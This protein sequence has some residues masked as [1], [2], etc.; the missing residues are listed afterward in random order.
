MVWMLVHIKL[1]PKPLILCPFFCSQSTTVISS[2]MIHSSVSSH[3]LSRVFFIKITVFF[4][5]VY[6]FIFFASL[7]KASDFSLCPSSLLL[8][9]L[10]ILTII[11]SSSLLGWLLSPT[12]LS[13]S[14]VFSCS[15]MKNIFL[16]HFIWPDF[17]VLFLCVWWWWWFSCW[18]MSDSLW[19]HGL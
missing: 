7:L 9:S 8:S 1:A 14:T 18:V 15:K 13:S 19:P 5:S 3:C 16:C 11:T 12:P 6:F 4:I 17:L 2:L 10:N